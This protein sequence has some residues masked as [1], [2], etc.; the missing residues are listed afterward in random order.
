M[1]VVLT[2]AD[3]VY[4]PDLVVAAVA[5]RGHD[6]VRVD[7]DDFPGGHRVTVDEGGAWSF[8]DRGGAVVDASVVWSRRRWP[9]TRS[10][11]DERYAAGAAAQARALFH[12]WLRDRGDE[13]VNAVDAEDR[14]EDKVLQLRLARELGFSVPETL[15]SNDPDRVRG[16]VDDVRADGGAVVT[17]LLVPL[18][19]SMQGSAGFFFTAEVDD[20]ALA[21]IDAVVH[22]PQIFQ[23]R[24]DKQLELRVQ[25]VGDRVFC[26]ALAASAVDWRLQQRGTWTQHALPPSTSER[27]LQLCRDLGLVTGAIDL[28]VDQAGAERFL[29]INPAGEWGFLQRDTDED[30]AGAIADVLVAAAG[31]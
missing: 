18:L 24:V 8:V 3:D 27:C 19:S 10:V 28:V 11:V 12:A 22:A 6:V 25:V 26:G 17:K 23:R 16:F 13:V 7:S 15:I 14:A 9:G 2:I 30:I 1:I 21:D 5:A 31:K 4:V 29:E 20:A